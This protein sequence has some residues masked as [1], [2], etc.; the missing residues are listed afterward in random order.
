MKKEDV[1]DRILQSL[2][3]FRLE[4]LKKEKITTEDVIKITNEITKEFP[5]TE[6]SKQ[7]NKK[8]MI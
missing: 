6:F 3:L 2:I 5:D 8:D 7:W 1:N 4:A